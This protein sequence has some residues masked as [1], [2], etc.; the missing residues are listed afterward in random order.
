MTRGIIISVPGNIWVTRK[1]IRPA[2]P[3]REAE[4][5]EGV[6]RRWQ[7]RKIP[8]NGRGGGDDDAVPELAPEEPVTLVRTSSVVEVV[9]AIGLG[10]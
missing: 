1:D 10:G 5:A 4:A 9:Q 3:P 7:A 2:G 6:G 8:K